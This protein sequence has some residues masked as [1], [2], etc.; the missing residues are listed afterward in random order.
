MSFNPS[1][2]VVTDPTLQSGKQIRS[3][4][5][6]IGQ[7]FGENH[8]SMNY[9]PEAAGTHEALVIVPIKLPDIPPVTDATQLALY[10]KIVGGPAIPELF[11]KPNN[12]QSEIQLTFPSILSDA[13]QSQQYTFIAGPFVIY[14]GNVVN[15]IQNQQVILPKMS[16]ILFVGLTFSIFAQ[17]LPVNVVGNIFEIQVTQASTPKTVYYV[18]IG[19]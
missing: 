15:P 11:F 19:I 9:N 14:A 7:S 13:T 18:A 17:G 10:S 5:Q 8:S 12:N 4:F 2:P 16:Q 1:I 3:N 6:S